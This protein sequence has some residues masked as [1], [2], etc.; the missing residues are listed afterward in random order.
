MVIGLRVRGD[1]DLVGVVVVRST[2]V[3]IIIML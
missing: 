3:I 2:I 1:E